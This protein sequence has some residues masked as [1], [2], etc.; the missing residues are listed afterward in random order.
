MMMRKA[1]NMMKKRKKKRKGKMKIKEHLTSEQQL[2]PKK[3]HYSME[4]LHPSMMENH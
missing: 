1:L 4:W 2:I 3:D